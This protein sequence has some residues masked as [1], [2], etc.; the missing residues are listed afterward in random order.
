MNRFGW[1]SFKPLFLVSILEELK[2][3]KYYFILTLMISQLLELK[4]I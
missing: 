1:F 4:I 3:E 2:M